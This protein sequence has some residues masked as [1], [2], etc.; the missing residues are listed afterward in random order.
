MQQRSSDKITFP[1]VWANTCC[2]HPLHVADEMELKDAMGVKTAARRKLEQ[3]LGIDPE[4]VPVSCF[5]FLTRVHYKAGSDGIW[6]EHEIDHI[7]ICRPPGGDVRVRPNANEVKAVRWLGEA[8]LQDF[9]CNSDE[10]GDK[11]SPWFKAIHRELM[12][13]WWPALRAGSFDHLVSFFRFWWQPLDVFISTCG[14]L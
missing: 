11:F 10:R 3:E 8:A 9:V 13:S 2:S 4:E 5:Q 6:G 14:L 12:P 7:L 1:E